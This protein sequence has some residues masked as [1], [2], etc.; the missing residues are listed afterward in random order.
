MAQS[1]FF[2]Y[3]PDP[4]PENRQHGH[5]SPHPHGL[6]NSPYQSQCQD[7]YYQANMV[8]TRPSSSD[9]QCSYGPR[10][11]YVP[12]SLMTPVASPQPMYQ[13]PT[14]L[15]QQDSPYLH[16]LDTDFSDMRFAPA[17]PPLS[18]SGS[19]ISSP[20]S[21]CEFLPTPVNS[22][23]FQGEGLEGVKMGCEEEVFSEIL[24]G[25]D[26]TRSASPPM[27]PGAYFCNLNTCRHDAT[28]QH[29]SCVAA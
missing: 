13:K 24:A 10:T 18:S 17:T 15:I 27:T 16:P 29:G 22:T 6:P 5:F 26:W 7:G 4:S 2:Y 9:S 8:F 23:F 21:S 28:R 12:Q 3:N 25:G 1:P 20:P 11:A 19:A 14:I